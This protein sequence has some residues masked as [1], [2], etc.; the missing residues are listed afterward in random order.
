MIR[1]L[2]IDHNV[3]ADEDGWNDLTAVIQQ[4][5]LQVVMSVWNLF[6]IASAT[7]ERQKARRLAYVESLSPWWAMDRVET[8]EKEL[9]RFIFTRYF[10]ANGEDIYGITKHLS[11]A[12]AKGTRTET[13]VGMKAADYVR[14]LKGVDLDAEKKSVMRA[15]QIHRDAGRDKRKEKEEERFLAWLIHFMPM[16]NA[17]GKLLKR[18][19][20]V[21]LLKRC[22][23]DRKDLF[24][25]S[26]AI[27]VEDQLEI[28]RTLDEKRKP[29]VGDGV[30]LQHSV[31]AMAFCDFY[32]S[33]DGASRNDCAYVTKWLPKHQLATVVANVIEIA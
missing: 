10:G 28:A 13:K 22:W 30:D 8:Q 14:A 5:Q 2:Y 26:P 15:L 32:M 31:V 11:V 17:D 33:K 25:S 6:E 27:A 19:E 16:R 1:T 4:N 20:K 18:N 21:A 7:D 23:E 29:Q 3:L 12:V 24:A 9:R